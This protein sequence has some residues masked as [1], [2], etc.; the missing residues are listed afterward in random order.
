MSTIRIYVYYKV[1]KIQLNGSHTI[2]KKGIYC[3]IYSNNIPYIFDMEYI[4]CIYCTN[5]CLAWKGQW[6]RGH[7]VR[8]YALYHYQNICCS[9]RRGAVSGLFCDWLVLFRMIGV[10]SSSVLFWLV[11]I[12]TNSVPNLYPEKSWSL[13]MM[14]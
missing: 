3:S 5:I 10:F 2:S 1:S 6:T 12:C 7:E 4:T 13:W 11:I 8:W 9:I 14:F